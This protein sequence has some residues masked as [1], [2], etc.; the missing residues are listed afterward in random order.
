MSDSSTISGKSRVREIMA[1][2]RKHHFL[3]NFY[4]QTNPEEICAALEELGPTFIKLG[5]ILSTRAD[6]VSPSYIKALSKLRDDVPADPFAS[7]EQTFEEETGKKISAVFKDFDEQPFASA[8]IGQVH[9]AHLQ[10]G[11]PVVVKVQHPEVTTLVN[12]DLHLLQRAVD[13]LKYVPTE[14]AVVNPTAVIT[15]LSR[16]LRAE[17]DT[18]REVQNGE[19]F[20]R[21]NNQ[22]GIIRVPKVYR[23]YCAPK[24]LVNQLM[25]G[26]S[27]QHLVNQKLSSDQATKDMQVQTREMIAKTLVNNFIKQVFVD[28]FFQA[29][30]HP[31]NIL[32]E[33]VDEPE[34]ATEHEMSRQVG[35][36]NFEY[37]RQGVLPPYRINLIDFGMM[38]RLTPAMADGI[39]KIVL[40]IN[41]K[42]TRQI[43]QAILAVCNQTGPVDEQQFFTDLGHFLRPYMS[44]GLSEIDFSTLLY[45]IIHLC[46]DN[47]L[48]MKAE[49]TMLVRAFGILEGTVAKLD[50]NLS[51][52][53][54]ARPFGRRYLK[55]HFNLRNRLEDDLWGS[56]QAGHQL[57]QLPGHVNDFL[58]A[59]TNG[60]ARLNFK[61]QNEERISQLL[62]RITNRLVVALILA[63]IIVGSSL[64]VEGS[65]DHPHIY[66]LGVTGY[67][68][69]IVIVIILVSSELITRWRQ[70]RARKKRY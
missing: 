60:D 37:Q 36:V 45:Q 11:T 58:D 16:S 6:L 67:S 64:L 2:M 33:Q 59:L 44:T 69:A 57:I 35:N 12:T 13:L 21:L 43:G 30:P 29:D 24:I 19:E 56:Y 49:V 28:H 32:I 39:A 20:Y 68:I 7:V 65:A 31:G 52:M 26:Q 5:Q 14:K 70:K 1:V 46:A 15:E 3:R 54:V 61:Y 47:H 8:S 66:R 63:A 22:A 62:L 42:N 17:I 38:G 9:H 4:R 51:M 55:Q 34:I 27:I 53:E 25:K 10:D 50:P 18:M 48:Q 40:A 41:S 23:E